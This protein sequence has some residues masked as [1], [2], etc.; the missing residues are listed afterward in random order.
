MNAA[1]L[2]N[3]A[4]TNVKDALKGETVNDTRKQTITLASNSNDAFA[5][6]VV[7]KIT[8]NYGSITGAIKDEAGNAIPFAIVK[9][10]G[11]RR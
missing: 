5:H 11:A 4:V 6:L 3:L 2:N 9:I 7:E 1:Q 8:N 10:K